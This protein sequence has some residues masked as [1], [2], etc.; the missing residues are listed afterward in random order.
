MDAPLT[1]LVL[2][3]GVTE[4]RCNS[5]TQSLRAKGR[6][7]DFHWTFSTACQGASIHGEIDAPA[8]CFVGLHYRNPP[9]GHHDC[10]NTKIARCKLTLERDGE[11]PRVLTTRDRAAFEILTDDRHGIPIVT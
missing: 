4:Y 8:S 2:R 10:L 1:I 7:Q 11:A 6:Y 5:L 3:D 9:G